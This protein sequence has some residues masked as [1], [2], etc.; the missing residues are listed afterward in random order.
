MLT[1]PRCGE[2]RQVTVWRWRRLLQCYCDTCGWTWWVL[3]EPEAKTV[4]RGACEAFVRSEG[5]RV[6]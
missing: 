6:G 3:P 1:C 4:E 2:D 5:N